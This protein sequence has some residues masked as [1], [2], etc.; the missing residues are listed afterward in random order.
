MTVLSYEKRSA[1]LTW[2]VVAWRGVVV[3][4][5]LGLA[6]V[7][8]DW[9][10]RIRHEV[11]DATRD[12]RFMPNVANA[13]LWG[14]NANAA[15]ITNLYD[16][17]L[18]RQRFQNY[19]ELDYPPL[20]LGMATVWQWWTARKY[21]GVSA[22]QSE[23]EFTEPMLWSDT[24]SA[25]L[26]AVLAFLLIRMWIIRMDDARRAPMQP[27][28]PFRGV[29]PG[30]I[31]ATLLYLNPS[32]IWDGYIWV[33]WDIW[34]MPFFLAAVLLGC[35]D[36]WFL[37]GALLAI[38]MCFKGQ[39]IIAS[40]VM[41]LWPLFQG[42][43]GAVG[44]LIAGLGLTFMMIGFP[45]MKP[46]VAA[47]EWYAAV[48]VAMGI[49]APLL[50]RRRIRPKW[51]VPLLIVIALALAW[52]WQANASFAVRLLP[53][54]LVGLLMLARFLP[55]RALPHVYAAAVT[56]MILLMIPVYGA[57]TGWF[58]RGFAYGADHNKMMS[59]PSTYNVP[60]LTRVT[61]NWPNSSLYEVSPFGTE[62]LRIRTV[63]G[64]IYCALLLLCG[65]A[66]ARHD[67]N[68][69]VRFLLAITLPWLLFYMLLT[70]MFPRYLM[71]AAIVACL[72]PAMG[73]GMTLLGILISIIATLG[74]MENHYQFS[75][76][77]A[78]KLAAIDHYLLRWLP[79]YQVLQALDPHLGWALVLIA[80]IM[81]YM[82]LAPASWVRGR[83][84]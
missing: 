34:P 3:L 65:F 24:I 59:A 43:I 10:V 53:L 18:R 36:W 79:N 17:V 55:A 78:Q 32:A 63:L 23:F 44:R 45:W 38:G 73:M 8:G 60:S 52:P 58:Q 37:A 19:N 27:K 28:P 46:S 50:L 84:R 48:L 1:R 4:F 70:Q 26:A 21:P 54:A 62:K 15:G 13:W 76:V 74:I 64:I 69:D 41:L 20:R 14:R 9:G 30:M 5:L 77:S 83:A 72:L 12:I 29:I 80:L 16:M 11:Y 6:W 39:L 40:P 47:I 33:Q 35:I 66:A 68:R 67:R 57:S 51:L 2:T 49:L 22:W 7:I 71:Y 82:A 81:L 31:G 42:R 25:M 61:L 75:N 56:V